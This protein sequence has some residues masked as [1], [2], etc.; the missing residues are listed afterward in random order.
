MGNAV[1]CCGAKQAQ[2]EYGDLD[3]MRITIKDP[4]K[5]KDPYANV[6][7]GS[8]EDEETADST[9]GKIPTPPPVT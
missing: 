4:L 1:K 5:V 7:E 3:N 8:E 9:K 6:D 2:A